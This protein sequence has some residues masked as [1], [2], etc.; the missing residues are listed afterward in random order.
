MNFIIAIIN[1]IVVAL[2]PRGVL[3]LLFFGIMVMKSNIASD[4]KY[5]TKVNK[6]EHEMWDWEEFY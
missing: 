5:D 3:I 4:V 6:F 1:L 2:T